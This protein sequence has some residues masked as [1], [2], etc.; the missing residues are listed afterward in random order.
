MRLVPQEDAPDAKK[1][2]HLKEAMALAD[3]NEEKQLVLSALGNVPT[4]DA[5]ALVASHLDNPSLKEEACLAAVTIAEKIA[6]GHERRVRRGDE[7]GRKADGRQEACRPGHRYCQSS[8]EV[9]KANEG[10]TLGGVL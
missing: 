5:L 7:A 6:P 1:F 4:A 10:E 2:D 8:E 3:R 9:A